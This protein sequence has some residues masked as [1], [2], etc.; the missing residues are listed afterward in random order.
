MGDNEG[1]FG[2]LCRQEILK[3]VEILDAR[4]HEEGL[5]ATIFF[6]QQGFAQRDRVFLGNVGADSEAVDRRRRDDG[7][8]ANT[9]KRHLERAWNRR[10]R[11]G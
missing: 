6:A 4:R 9:G 8:I 7:E 10:G 11:Q 5:P 3:L 2:H 1:Y